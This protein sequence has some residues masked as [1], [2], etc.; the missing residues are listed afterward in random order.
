MNISC[1]KLK[2]FRNHLNKQVDLKTD[3]TLILGK[4]GSGKT[5]ILEAIYVMATGK[6]QRAKYDKD[7]IN[8]DHNFCSIYA[9]V[10]NLQDDYE[11]EMQIVQ[12]N[13]DTNISSKAAKVNKV[14]KSILAFTGIFNAVLFVPEDIAML[15]GSP[16]ERRRYLDLLLIQTDREY[17]RSLSAYTKALRQRNKLLEQICETGVGRDQLS[18]WTEQVVKQGTYICHKR[19]DFIDFAN[20]KLPE[21]L[22]ALENHSTDAKI[23]YKHSKITDERMATYADKEVWAKSTL[24]GPHREDFAMTFN[25]H[26]VAEFGSRGQQRTLLLSLKL[27][28]LDFIE[29]N[30]GERPVLLLDD[31]FSELDEQHRKTIF[32]VVTKQQTVIT[33]AESVKILGMEFG[34]VLSL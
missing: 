27:I 34:A 21:L 31:I 18:F 6:S 4:N 9:Q 26:N 3:L 17:R 14:S 30:K 12:E 15:T 2:N 25:G 11:L 32:D 33:S 10:T 23:D 29:K 22:R 19:T 24:I 5:N 20:S 7:L 16:S 13:P 8:Y 28:E 1:L